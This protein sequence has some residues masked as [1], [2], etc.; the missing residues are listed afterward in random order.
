MNFYVLLYDMGGLLMEYIKINNEILDNIK[1][2]VGSKNV[3]TDKD[4]IAT[5]FS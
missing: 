3:I 4:L 5:L 2:I 1:N